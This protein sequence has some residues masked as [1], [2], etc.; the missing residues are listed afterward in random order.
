[1]TDR[2]VATT[3]DDGKGAMAQDVT[4]TI[5][6]SIDALH[7]YVILFY[8]KMI[9]VPEKRSVSRLVEGLRRV[10]KEKVREQTGEGRRKRVIK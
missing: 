4:I 9:R 6:E 8:G 10:L 1:M 3:V 7:R 2:N 5:F